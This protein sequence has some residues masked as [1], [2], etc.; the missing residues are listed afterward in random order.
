V[1]APASA[2]SPPPAS[3]GGRHAEDAV[4]T[5]LGVLPG[6][7]AALAE[8]AWVSV[9]AALIAAVGHETAQLGPVGFAVSA[10]GGLVAARALGTRQ[11]WPTLTLLL[12][13]AAA[14]IGWLA[15]PFARS[16][17]VSLDLG[18][19]VAH[20]PAGWLCGLAFLRG[21]AHA[22]PSSSHGA[23]ETL[24]AFALPGLA[25]P[26]LIGGVLDQPWRSQFL[27]DAQIGV[28]LFLVAGTVGVGVARLSALRGPAGFDW[29]GNRAWLLLIVVLVLG[30]SLVALPLA[31]IVGPAVQVAIAALLLPAIV[32]GTIVGLRQV[33]ARAIVAYLVLCTALIVAL[34]VF[35][36]AKVPPPAE[37]EGGGAFGETTSDPT[38]VYAAI[39][40]GLLALLIVG[41]LL[42]A[43]LWSRDALSRSGGDVPEERWIDL[44]E[45]SGDGGRTRRP[46]RRPRGRPTPTGAAEAYLAALDDLQRRPDLRRLANESPAEH[47][48]RLRAAGDGDLA[49]DLLAADYELVRFGSVA[50][51]AGEDRRAIA[52]WRRIRRLERLRGAG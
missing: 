40:I 29:R 14:L 42:L 5:A 28:V 50:V 33:S 36:H 41:V 48:G 16:A 22:R 35:G 47:A 18:G 21:S 44:G 7:L 49:L 34:S 51:T 30:V 39:G 46:W 31:T 20:H 15:D 13:V 37:T 11:G 43:R 10:V 26:V 8:G 25:I 17:L 2:P 52:R 23:M 3:D 9:V 1:N 6:A 12:T 27:G 32:L 45:T 19:A 4:A 24:L 38:I